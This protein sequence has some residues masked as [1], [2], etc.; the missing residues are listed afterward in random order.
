MEDR[1]IPVVCSRGHAAPGKVSDGC[2]LC[3]GKRMPL[4]YLLKGTVVLVIKFLPGASKAVVVDIAAARLYAAELSEL[5]VANLHNHYQNVA[6]EC[7][8][9]SVSVDGLAI[10]MAIVDDNESDAVLIAEH[11]ETLD[12]LAKGKHPN[13]MQIAQSISHVCPLC[14]KWLPNNPGADAI[15]ARHLAHQHPDELDELH[16]DLLPDTIVEIAIAIQEQQP[17][18]VKFPGSG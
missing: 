17:N 14:G 9:L 7:R 10:L 16:I 4:L 15:V 12:I 18:P 5:T 2:H 3:D 13:R 11:A 6:K 1:N 8:V